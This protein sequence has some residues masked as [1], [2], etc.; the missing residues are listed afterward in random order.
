MPG[1]SSDRPVRDVP[2][3]PV[4]P[5]VDAPVE[6]KSTD[7]PDEAM[8]ESRKR[9]SDMSLDELE[10]N[11]GQILCDIRGNETAWDHVNENLELIANSRCHISACGG[12]GPYERKGFQ[13]GQESRVLRADWQGTEKYQVGRYGQVPRTREDLGTIALGGDGF[14]DKGRTGS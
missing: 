5:V 10:A 8:L 2:M 13:S 3:V 1:S 14:Q 12:D 11:I 7:V 9:Q 4:S 6:Q